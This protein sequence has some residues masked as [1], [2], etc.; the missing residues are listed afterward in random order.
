[1]QIL[2][3]PDPLQRCYDT[4]VVTIGNFDG[5]HRGHREIFQRMKA[6]SERT[7]YASV[8]VTFDPHPLAVI[9][10]D[11]APPLITT[12]EQKAALIAEEGIDCLAVIDFS[13]DFSRMSAEAFVREI[14]C[15]GLGM[16]HIII[17]HDYAFGQ[18][19]QGNYE[20]LTK[21]GAACGFTLEDLEPVGAEGLIYSSSLARRM[22]ADGDVAAVVSVLG[23]Y[24]MIAGKVV[25]GRAMGHIIGF[26]TANIATRN[27]LVPLDGVYAVKVRFYGKL[28]DGACSIGIN[29]TFESGIRAIEVFLLNFNGDLYGADIELFFVR[30]L[31]DVQKFPDVDAL[32][33]AIT[34]DISMAR[35]ILVGVEP[36]LIKP[37]ISQ[38]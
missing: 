12:P 3:N 22:I 18:G 31:R 17:G 35:N 16:R 2:R 36:G 13:S 5:V 37:F 9:A 33:K 7:G 1:M 20:L 38:P 14:L 34:G 29:P 19:R 30:R 32:V 11:V 23:R 24:H 4:S 27:E 26:P 10:P 28:Y 21:L 25:H 8:V 6:V 15:A